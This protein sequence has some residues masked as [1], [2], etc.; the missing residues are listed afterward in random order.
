LADDTNVLKFT[1]LHHGAW[2]SRSYQIN[3]TELETLGEE[4]LL[5]FSCRCPQKRAAFILS[6]GGPAASSLLEVKKQMWIID[7]KQCS[8]IIGHGSHTKGRMHMV[9]IGR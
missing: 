8:N 2:L 4:R 6:V 7:P 3:I 9:G 5:V 1:R